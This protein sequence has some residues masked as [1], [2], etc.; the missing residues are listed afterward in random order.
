MKKYPSIEQFRNT[1][2]EVRIN[3]DYVGK[4]EEGKSIYQHS[5]PYPTIT[6]QGSVK[7]HGTNAAVVKYKDGR[8]EFQSRERIL[9]LT[10]DNSAFFRTMSNKN[11]DFMFQGVGFDEY[12]AVYGE[13][14]G[15]GIQKGAAVSE[16][17]PKFIIFGCK[18]DDVWKYY[19]AEDT[20]QSIYN[21]YRFPTYHIDINFNTPELIQ[22]ELVNL[23]EE[24]EKECP[25]GKQFGISGIGEGIVWSAKYND[26]YYQFKTKGEKHSVTKVTTIASVDIEMVESI[27]EMIDKTCT[28]NRLLQG[29]SWLKENNKDLDIKSTG[30]FLRWVVNDI[31]KEETDTIIKNNLDPKKINSAC[32]NK[33]RMWFINYINSNF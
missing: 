31:I 1:V 18:V 28:E 6:F 32:S 22:N 8:I 10:S 11:L 15:K 5:T 20:D 23:T 7:I 19:N 17:D 13:W 9:T 14:C 27:N 12:M 2:K 33:A 21:I 3:H 16:L 24:V 25:V 26:N 29:I 30:D 4:D